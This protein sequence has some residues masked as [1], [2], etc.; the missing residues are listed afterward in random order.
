M[1]TRPL[2]LTITLY[3][4]LVL[5]LFSFL[6]KKACWKLHSWSFGCCCPF[7][8]RTYFKKKS[9]GIFMYQQISKYFF[10]V[11]FF[12]ISSTFQNSLDVLT[13]VNDLKDIPKNCSGAHYFLLDSVSSNIPPLR[14]PYFENRLSNSIVSFPL[15][16]CCQH[17]SPEKIRLEFLFSLVST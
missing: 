13:S 11:V 10:S 12:L 4:W 15:F 5:I 14:N 2:L 1:L 6:K 3:K 16:Y 17:C 7:G 8:L 9:L